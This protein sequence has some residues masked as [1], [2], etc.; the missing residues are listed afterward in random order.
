MET[1]EVR[2]CWMYHNIMDLYGDK[3][4]MMVLKNRCEQRNIQCQIETMEIGDDVD[5]TSYDLLFLGGGADKEQI[6]LMDDL[7]KRKQEI[8]K[9]MEQGTFVV[10]ICGGYQLF[11][12]YYIAADGTKINGLKFFDYYTE[13][14]KNL[15]RCIGDIAISSKLDDLETIIVGFENHGG[16]TRNVDQPLGSVLSGFGNNMEDHMEGFYNGQV[17]ATYMHGPLFPKNPKVA[18][19]VIYKCLHKQDPIFQFH[20]LVPLNDELERKARDVILRR[21]KISV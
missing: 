20:D 12:Q 21:L 11:G 18:D 4:N 7:L 3:G 6:L 13:A 5:L 14:S 19:F 2:V 16:Q 10:L 15:Q 17:L 1:R 8:A 9:A